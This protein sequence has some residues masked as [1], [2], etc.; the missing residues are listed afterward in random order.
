MKKIALL[1]VV[2]ASSVFANASLLIDGFVDGAYDTGYIQGNDLHTEAASVLG[3]DR[4][5]YLSVLDNPLSEDAKA[6]VQGT[7]DNG[8]FSHSAGPGLKSVAVLA[9]GYETGFGYQDSN[10]NLSAT[11]KLQVEFLSNDL[12]LSVFA[13]LVESNGAG[14]IVSFNQVNGTVNPGSS[15]ATFDFTGASLLGSADTVEFQFYNNAGGDYTIGSIEAVP[16]PASMALL[17]IGAAGVA[18][19]RRK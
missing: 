12:P 7:I 14:G 9:Y 16:E 1:I 11:P 18:R 17:A 6:K 2:G 3:G 8:T 19:K 4:T 13:F 5:T 15:T 10:F